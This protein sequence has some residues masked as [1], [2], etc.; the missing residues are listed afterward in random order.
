M[1]KIGLVMIFMLVLFFIISIVVFV[2]KIDYV[3]L[4]INSENKQIVVNLLE[5]QTDYMFSISENV[6]LDLCYKYLTRI[7]IVYNFPD[8]EDYTLY[9]NND[10][11]EFSLDNSNYNLSNYIGKNGRKGFRLK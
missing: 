10:K 11:V 1:K 4:N 2:N 9:C 7:E 6:N 5:E 8:G 3:Y